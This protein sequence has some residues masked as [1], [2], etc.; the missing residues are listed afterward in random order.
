MKRILFVDDEPLL[1][2]GLRA[3]L[4]RHRGVWEVGFVQ[5]AEEALAHLRA[6][7]CDILVADLKMP[8]MDGA[9]LLE[10]VR[11]EFPRVLRLLLSGHADSIGGLRKVSAAQHILSKPCDGPTL[12]DALGRACALHELVY[13]EPL[14]ALTGGAEPWPPLPALYAEL[15]Q[16]WA[17]PLVDL[18]EMARRLELDGPLCA[19][20][21]RAA[22]D[23]GL[24]SGAELGTAAEALAQL[25]AGVVRHLVLWAAAAQ[26]F[27]AAGV[28][29]AIIERVEA[30]SQ[31]VARAARRLAA[32]APAAEQVVASAL[33][34][35]VGELLLGARRSAEVVLCEE[36]ARLCGEERHVAERAVLGHSHAEA[37]ASLLCR[38]GL[39]HDV[40]EA[41]AYHHAP[42]PGAAEAVAVVHLADQLAYAE[43]ASGR[44][45]STGAAPLRAACK[46]GEWHE[47]AGTLPAHDPGGL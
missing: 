36:R 16:L 19:A 25:G 40:V 8:G 10:R 21:L 46:L 2:D 14:L 6:R 26:A 7:P 27:A 5:S 17:E 15:T 47:R 37:G 41:V 9:T 4:R 12:I 11:V 42:P 29:L 33:L 3:L 35:D 1:L 23:S 18:P 39:P 32:D 22:R 34:H 44:S 30:H 20:V 43:E 24:G 28:P 13:A 45:P 38:W 31:R